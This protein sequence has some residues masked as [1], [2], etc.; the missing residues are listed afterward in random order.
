MSAVARLQGLLFGAIDARTVGGMRIL[1]AV[2]LLASHLLMYPE[3]AVLLSDTGPATTEMVSTWSKHARWSYYDGVDD[4]GTLRLIHLVGVIP[5]VGMLV[6][7][8]SRLMVLLALVVQVAVHHRAPW[9]QHG[10]DRVMR[11]ATLS[12]LLVPCGAG[13]SVD[14]WLRSRRPGAP[15]ASPLVPMVTHRVIQVQWMIIYG[16]T[17]LA[18]VVG[19][20]WQNGDA[21]YYALSLRTFQRF[22]ALTEQLLSLG[23]VQALLKLGTWVTLAWELAFPLL[24]LSARTRRDTL[25][26]G[27]VLHAG[28]ALTMMVGTFSYIMVW[29]YLAFLGP[30]WAARLAAW[31][32]G[33][34]KAEQELEQDE[35]D[36]R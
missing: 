11:L 34:E 22:P 33:S 26:V 15:V 18:K 21:L 17:G 30:D 8:Q 2:L 28:I 14:A 16:F 6:G 25:L 32:P 23:L 3:L 36:H 31:L 10:G 20:T 27:L 9:A 13:W 35:H 29:G 4:L 12:L 24:I 19:G 7:W 1:L 5:L